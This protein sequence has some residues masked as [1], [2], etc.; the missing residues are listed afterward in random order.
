LEIE[1]L[2]KLM[3]EKIFKEKYSKAIKERPEPYV[4]YS[5]PTRA[6]FFS[7]VHRNSHPVYKL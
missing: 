1:A 7:R 3:C 6:T 2:K 5:G 4:G